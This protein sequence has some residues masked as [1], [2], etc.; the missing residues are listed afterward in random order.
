MVMHH[1]LFIIIK[2]NGRKARRLITANIM[3]TKEER[4][5]LD[6]YKKRILSRPIQGWVIRNLTPHDVV[7]L[8]DKNR[9]TGTIPPS[10]IV[11][12]VTTEIVDLGTEKFLNY[13]LDVLRN[14]EY[15]RDFDEDT[16]WVSIKISKTEFGEVIDLP[17]PDKK[18]IYIVSQLVKNSPEGRLRTD[19]VVPT[20]MV[21]D[22]NNNII[23]CRSFGL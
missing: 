1:W 23:G 20:E 5:M 18:T 19:L 16:E 12:R 8:D 21:R 11:A 17:K 3:I 2:F 13:D 15:I 7:V 22:E 4:Q 9:I 10:G 14:G 6:E